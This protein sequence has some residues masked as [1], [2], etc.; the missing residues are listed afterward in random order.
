MGLGMILY[1]QGEI[2]LGISMEHLK[3]QKYY[4]R[5]ITNFKV[6]EMGKKVCVNGILP[7]LGE[8][9]E[10]WWRALGKN[11]SIMS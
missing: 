3:G 10:W 4:L 7:R 6:R 5:S 11:E 1:M 2:I 8:N 9:E